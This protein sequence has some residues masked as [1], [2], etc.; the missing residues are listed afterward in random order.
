MLPI[1]FAFSFKLHS[2][3]AGADDWFGPDKAKHFFTAAFVQSFSYAAFRTT[4]MSSGAS[5]AGATV[6]TA[7]A[8]FGK[9]LWDASGHGTPSARDL[10][11][12]A[13]GAGAAS[14]LLMKTR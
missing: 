1:V 5:L 7:A 14:L 2:P 9:E 4:G 10:V 11:W 8:S 3:A 6:A 12:D 13:A